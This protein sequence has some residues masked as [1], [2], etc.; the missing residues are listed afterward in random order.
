MYYLS[1]GNWGRAARPF[2]ESG[3]MTITLDGPGVSPGRRRTR[4]TLS[5]GTALT[6]ISASAVEES[7][8]TCRRMSI[9]EPQAPRP[10]ASPM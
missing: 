9:D 4:S 5:V 2:L 3:A 1:G 10:S 6:A 8:M 7:A